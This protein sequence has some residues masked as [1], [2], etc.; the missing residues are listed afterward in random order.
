MDSL[1]DHRMIDE[2]TAVVMDEH[3]LSDIFLKYF[4]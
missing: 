3:H 1:K 4:Y 2:I